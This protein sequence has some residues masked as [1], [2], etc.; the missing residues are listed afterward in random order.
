MYIKRILFAVPGARGNIAQGINE[1]CS[2]QC[3]KIH[4]AV[5]WN[6]N[7]KTHKVNIKC[8]LL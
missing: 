6:E 2:N 1:F 4:Q 5:L 8:Y 3:D 7:L